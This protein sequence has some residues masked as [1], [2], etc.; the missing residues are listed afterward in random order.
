[1]INKKKRLIKKLN[2]GG[3]TM[4]VK[5]PNSVYNM[6]QYYNI[7]VIVCDVIAHGSA[8]FFSLVS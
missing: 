3:L 5:L 8:A 1:M 7:I 4:G 2:F 6:H